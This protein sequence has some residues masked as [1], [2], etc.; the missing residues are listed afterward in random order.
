MAKNLGGNHI[1][2]HMKMNGA[3][4]TGNEISESFA[5]FF[6]KKVNE[7]VNTTNVDPGV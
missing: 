3:M 7:I 1:L 4:V 2:K 5:R 6:E